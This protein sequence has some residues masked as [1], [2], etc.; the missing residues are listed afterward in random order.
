MSMRPFV[1]ETKTINT[2]YVH[3]VMCTDAVGLTSLIEDEMQYGWRLVGSPVWQ[4]PY[5]GLAGEAHVG[6]WSA[7]MTR[8]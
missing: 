1:E 6:M 5:Y 8:G 2:P 4:A 3:C 7:W